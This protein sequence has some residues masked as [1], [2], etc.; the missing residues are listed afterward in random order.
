MNFFD[1]RIHNQWSRAVLPRLFAMK[2]T[3]RD[4]K[5]RD[6]WKALLLGFEAM[7]G[8]LRCRLQNIP[9]ATA[10]TTLFLYSI[11]QSGT[12]NKTCWACK[13]SLAKLL[14][15][16]LPKRTSLIRKILKLLDKVQRRYNDLVCLQTTIYLNWKPVF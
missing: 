13:Q 2:K 9:T 14:G 12:F 15:T 10:T 8:N 6:W 7:F 16:K 1:R 3:L 5:R 4:Y 11:W